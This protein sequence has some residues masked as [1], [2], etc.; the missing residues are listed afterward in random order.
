MF[1]VAKIWTLIVIPVMWAIMTPASAVENG[2]LAKAGAILTRL[3]PQDA[4]TAKHE[5]QHTV[6]RI[7]SIPENM[8]AGAAAA[9]VSAEGHWTFAN[10]KG[11]LFTAANDRE[12][13]TMADALFP[14]GIGARGL[15]LYLTPASV[16]V[17][18][19]ELK[20]L[21][22]GARLHLVI[23]GHDYPLQIIQSRTGKDKLLYAMIR[24]DVVV[25]ISERELFEEVI[26]RLEQP[27]PRNARVLSIVTGGPAAL[28]VRFNSSERAIERIAP[29]HLIAALPALSEQLVVLT[30]RLSKN[31]FIV[32]L[33]DGAEIKLD[34]K[35]IRL[36]A[37]QNDLELV[38]LNSKTPR[39]P[40]A[41]N[42]LFQKVDVDGLDKA[43]ARN[44]FADFVGSLALAASKVEIRGRILAGDR[45]RLSVA[46]LS[47]G[48][49]MPSVGLVGFIAELASE[50]AGT[51]LPDAVQLDMPGRARARE[52]SW[53]VLPWVPA[54]V[55]MSFAALF[56]TSLLGGGV[57]WRWWATIWPPETRYDYGTW[58]GYQAAR[59]VRCFAFVLLF[60]PIAGL[61]ALVRLMLGGIYTLALL[62]FARR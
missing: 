13:A 44:T 36:T 47:E 32:R 62:P 49:A 5:W 27:L 9:K 30:G 41:H 40:G 22:A 56:A 26:W 15:T 45:V 48:F 58:S 31:D 46:P 20:N 6:A 3:A 4:D 53:R 2:W 39:Q 29:E 42:W 24:Q 25:K 11:E 12:M 52:L 38:L 8:Q 7:Q 18:S 34:L 57:A 35:K 28:P 51:V 16:F 55:Q 14:A 1:T 37:A 50:V 19:R 17:Y 54:A 59:G 60:L 21:P 10:G 61:P 43:L 33:Q 23:A